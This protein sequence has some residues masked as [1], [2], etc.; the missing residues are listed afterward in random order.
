MTG[1]EGSELR[2]REEKTEDRELDGVEEGE[3]GKG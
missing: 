3:K 2:E 1:E